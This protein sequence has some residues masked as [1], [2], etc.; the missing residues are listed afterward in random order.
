VSEL[1][2]V[3]GETVV[4]AILEELSED[5]ERERRRLELRVERAFY[6]AGAALREL[7]DRRL[8]RSTHKT[9]EEYCRDRFG[10]SRRHPYRLIDAALVVDNLCPNGTQ[11]S[12]GTNWT[13]VLPTSERQVRDLISLE[14]E[15]QRQVWQRAVE[16][17]Q[18]K[19]PSG[20]IVKGIVEQIQE[21]PIP[22]EPLP[23][24]K[25]DVVRIC[26][27]GAELRRHLGYWGIIKNVGYTEC[28]V[29]ITLKDEDVR[30]KENQMRKIEQS[31]AKLL[32]EVSDRVANLAR[33]NL[34]PVVWAGLQAINQQEE[35]TQIQLNF[36]TWAE[37]CYG[38]G[39]SPN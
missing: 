21:C 33:C 32:R 20:K 39:N 9:F 19:V 31:K 18:G 29:H 13:Q 30:C 37:N 22:T 4:A 23:Y 27:G 26:R 12:L 2:A 5:E 11:G 25:G 6:E 36:L 3:E 38:I 14:P 35:I 15:L 34:D 16:I 17:A 7:R 28:M 1:S 8:Y 24:T 10:F